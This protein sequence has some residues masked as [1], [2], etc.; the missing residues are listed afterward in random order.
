LSNIESLKN[1]PNPFS[2]STIIEFTIAES[3]E[4]EIC[5]FDHS[6]KCIFTRVNE[7][8]L[9]GVVRYVWDAANKPAGVYRCR[10]RTSENEISAISLLKTE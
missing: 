4:I 9:P 10:I 2:S 1:Y 8:S 6:G 7:N 5:I 3:T